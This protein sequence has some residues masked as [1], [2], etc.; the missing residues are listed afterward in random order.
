[1]TSVTPPTPARRK[2]AHTPLAGTLSGR[3]PRDLLRL[4]QLHQP[5]V[6]HLSGHG[7]RGGE[8][9]L[10][11]TASALSVKESPTFVRKCILLDLVRELAETLRVN[12]I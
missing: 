3:D 11:S 12:L 6:L 4:L 10:D 9:L 7:A 5:Q 8:P 2:S 1:M